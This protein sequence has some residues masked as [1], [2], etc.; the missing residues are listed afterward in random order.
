MPVG[1]RNFSEQ[2]NEA[3]PL[4]QPLP[5]LRVQDFRAGTWHTLALSGELD[6]ASQP[7]FTEVLDR[8]R[9]TALEGIALDLSG[10]TFLDSTGIH[11][12]FTLHTR[13][14]ER[15]I[16][17]RIVP[18]PSQVQRVFSLCG[19]LDSLPFIDV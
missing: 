2:G 5:N 18:G 9:M 3:R 11:A 6:L 10:V 12:V 19:L 1:E 8:I 13:C 4:G 7:V 15:D 14:Q 16:A 17:L